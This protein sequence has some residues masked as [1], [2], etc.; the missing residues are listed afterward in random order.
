MYSI[1]CDHSHLFITNYFIRA[2]D[3]QRLPTDYHVNIQMATYN[4]TCSWRYC[5][6][7]VAPAGIT[8][9]KSQY[10][11]RNYCQREL[12]DMWHLFHV[13]VDGPRSLVGERSSVQWTI[14]IA[15]V[16]IL[17]LWTE[18]T[19]ITNIIVTSSLIK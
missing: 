11:T 6:L 4:Q 7:T 13:P 16:D 10:V 5:P 14:V 15:R 3:V 17:H 12:H 8:L 1:H 2:R 18:L 9:L 19:R